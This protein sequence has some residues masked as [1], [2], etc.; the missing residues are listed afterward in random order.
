MN[1]PNQEQNNAH[2]KT[3]DGYFIKEGLN[4]DWTFIPFEKFF[5]T[6]DLFIIAKK[7]EDLNK[8]NI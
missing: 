2:F 3:K 5:K 4:K 1:K 7:L 6:E 8:N